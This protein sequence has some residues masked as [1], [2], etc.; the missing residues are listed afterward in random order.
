M[1]FNKTHKTLADVSKDYVIQGLLKA[2]LRAL[3]EQVLAKTGRG[4]KRACPLKPLIVIWLVVAMA[5]YRNLSI[6]NVFRRLLH[7][8]RTAEPGLGRNPV[9]PEALV[10]AR[11]RLRAGPL[12]LLYRETVENYLE[13]VPVTF[14]GLREWAV[15][16]S[17]FTVPDTPANEVAFGR[18][19][20]QRGDAAY[21]QVRG[22]F[23]TAIALHQIR[24]AR[25]MRI[26]CGEQVGLPYL[27]RNLGPKDLVLVD[28]GLA[29]FGFFLLCGKKGAHYVARISAHWKPKFLQR[30][31]KGDSL[32]EVR[33][34][35]MARRK[36]AKGD[37][38]TTITARLLEFRVGH[39]ERVRLLTD[40]VDPAEYPAAELAGE[41]H[42]RWECELT[43][44]EVKIEL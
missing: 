3:G 13:P 37:R 39:G 9:T 40:L 4:S 25:F 30:L 6:P 1:L 20:C 28:R 27:L 19:T 18:H 42:R 32:V 17:E 38:D 8:A 44:K 12:K 7:C 21:P 26:S 43:Y 31:G 14:H 5:L 15:D 16:G 41:Y 10:H 23:L 36:L 2:D 22:V 29:S 35:S 33:P 24:D 11:E 34:G